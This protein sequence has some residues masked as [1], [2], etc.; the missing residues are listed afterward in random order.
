MI[1]LVL[2]SASPAR[3]ATL[4]TAGIEPVVV[5]SDVDEDA[6]LALA[7]AQAGHELSVPSQVAELAKAKARDVVGKVDLSAFGGDV[8][9]L[10]C[11]SLLEFD[12]ATQGKPWEPEVARERWRA[13]RGGSGVLHT[14][15]YLIRVPREG[16]PSVASAVSSTGVQ[17]ADL[18]DDEID[19]Y[20]ATG[21]P[22]QV[23]GGFTIDG[24]GGAFITAIQGDHHGVIGLSLPLLRDVVREVG[25]RYQDLWAASHGT[26]S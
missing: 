14:G 8:L 22:L 10:G 19:A 21:E 13:M 11:D 12:G 1:T 15:H 20:V 17:F 16:E 5:V 9:V 26:V 7:T 24:Y 3:L 23:A 2:A 6:A 18:D 4:R 25:L